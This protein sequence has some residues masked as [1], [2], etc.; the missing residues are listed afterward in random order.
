MIQVP[1]NDTIRT[2]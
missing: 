1:Q 2:F